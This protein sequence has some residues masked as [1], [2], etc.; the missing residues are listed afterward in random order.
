MAFRVGA[1]VDHRLHAFAIRE[2]EDA[3]SGFER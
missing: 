2:L 1:V 3:Q